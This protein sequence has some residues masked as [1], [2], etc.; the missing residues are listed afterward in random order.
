MGGKK[1]RFP[2][3]KS[4]SAIK[5]K[6]SPETVLRPPSVRKDECARSRKA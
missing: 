4:G 5:K 3:F 1:W 2:S 6:N